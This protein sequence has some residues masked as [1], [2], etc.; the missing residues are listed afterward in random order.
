MTGIKKIR[1]MRGLTQEKA[2]HLMG[3]T[4]NTWARWER[5]SS[6]ASPMCIQALARVFHNEL[7][8]VRPA[9]YEPVDDG[10]VHSPQ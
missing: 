2:A 3:V 9:W 1:R 7:E 4:V 10:L 6:L 5:G 8:K